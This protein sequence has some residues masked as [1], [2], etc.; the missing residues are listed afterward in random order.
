MRGRDTLLAAA[1]TSTAALACWIAPGLALGAAKHHGPAAASFA[2]DTTGHVD[3]QAAP[4]SVVGP[5][6]LTYQP[7]TSGT[8]AWASGQPIGL[9]Q[10]A[11]NPS[12]LNGTAATT[13]A[14]TPFDVEVTAPEFDRTTKVDVLDKLFPKLG[15]DFHLKTQSVNSVM[16][17]GHLNGTV[18]A[19]GVSG[20]AAT[21]DH[22]R[23]GGLDARTEDH[24]TRYTFPIRFAQLKL[25]PSWTIGSAAVPSTPADAALIPAAYMPTATTST[26]TTAAAELLA[27]PAAA[28]ATATGLPAV[29]VLL[30]PTATPEPSTIATLAVGLAG[31][32][33]ARRRGR[34]AAAR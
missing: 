2:Y 24:I 28:T 18:A 11:V 34:R 32:A 23:L 10:F 16:L 29:G 8:Y 33:I 21:I 26:T 1:R 12:S 20:V 3:V 5:A 22:I 30:E 25:P 6:T 15:R 7:V 13:F 14:N 9:G 31:L 17:T 4:G 19:N 27:P